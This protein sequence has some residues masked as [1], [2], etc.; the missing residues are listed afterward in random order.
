MISESHL[1]AADSLKKNV[2]CSQSGGGFLGTAI[3]GYHVV[4]GI[5]SFRNHGA[6]G[7]KPGQI[8]VFSRISSHADWIEKTI[9]K[10]SGKIGF[11]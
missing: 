8:T 2:I 10:V 1:C 4:Y 7:C 11:I 6:E 3:N 5:E 9:E